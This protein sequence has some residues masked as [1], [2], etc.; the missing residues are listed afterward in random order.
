VVRRSLAEVL[1]PP[2]AAIFTPVPAILPA[3][4]DVFTPIPAVFDA[5]AQA[6]HVTGVAP[7]LAAITDVFAAVAPIL[8]PIP[9]VFEAIPSLV[10]RGFRVG[11]RHRKRGEQQCGDH[12]LRQS[13][14][15]YPPWQALWVRRIG[16]LPELPPMRPGEKNGLFAPVSVAWFAE[17]GHDGHD[18]QERVNQ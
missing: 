14:H 12:E 13:T 10:S 3:I 5:V 17:D 6:A 16:P 2:V 7:I 4:A 8:S 15:V 11:D 18:E 1:T 9:Y